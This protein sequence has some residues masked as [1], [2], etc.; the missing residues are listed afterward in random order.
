MALLPND[1]GSLR[2][3]ISIVDREAAVR[4]G[5][6]AFEGVPGGRLLATAAVEHFDRRDRERW[7]FVRL[8]ALSLAGE[9]PAA[10]RASPGSRAPASRWASSSAP[11]RVLRASW[12]RWRWTW[13]RGWPTWWGA[14]RAGRPACSGSPSP[15]PTWCAS[16]MP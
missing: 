12:W 14:R 2:L 5:L 8:P 10:R 16:P 1:A 3:A 9:A 11:P 13:G 4:G 6:P 15:A 7:P